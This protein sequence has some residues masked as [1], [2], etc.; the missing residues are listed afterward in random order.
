MPLK[1]G[2][3]K[4]HLPSSPCKRCLLFFEGKGRQTADA[5]PG[6]LIPFPLTSQVGIP[7]TSYPFL[8]SAYLL[9]PSHPVQEHYIVKGEQVSIQ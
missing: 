4:L 8:M 9:S 5:D 2:H 6:A 1:I 7:C 3:F